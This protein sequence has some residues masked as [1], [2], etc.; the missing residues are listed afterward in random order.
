M[1][2]HALIQDEESKLLRF[3][4]QD[5]LEEGYISEK[6]FAFPTEFIDMLTNF[7]SMWDGQLRRVSVAKHRI[8]LFDESTPTVHSAPYRAAPKAREF[9][10]VKIENMLSQKIIEP[11][12]TEWAPR[13]VFA[14]KNHERLLFSVDYRK[15]NVV[16]KR[17]SYS[18]PNTEQCIESFGKAAIIFT[19]NANSRYWQVVK[20]EAGWDKIA[21]T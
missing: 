9:E 21:F 17:Y 4:S 7:Q 10:I 6:Y 2:R 3:L 12:Q 1:W 19:I 18:I 15:L 13:I 11:T 20:E 8:K 16:T 14:P 5:W